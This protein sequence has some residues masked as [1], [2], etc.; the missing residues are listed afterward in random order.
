[1][2]NSADEAAGDDFTANTGMDFKVC[3][4]IAEFEFWGCPNRSGFMF[5]GCLGRQFCHGL[6]SC[7]RGNFS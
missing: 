1:M 3:V 7:G 2:A 4:G 5:W 6:L